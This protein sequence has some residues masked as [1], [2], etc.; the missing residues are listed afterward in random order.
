MRLFVCLFIC[1]CLS[2]YVCRFL[3]LSLFA[4]LPL[5]CLFVSLS[6]YFIISQFTPLSM[7]FCCLSI[8]LTICVCLCVFLSVSSP[9]SLSVYRSV[10]LLAHVSF[11]L[12]VFRPP[13]RVSQAG[14]GPRCGTLINPHLSTA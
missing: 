3:C 12:S 5:A 2:C 10:C 1:L 8:H 6:V 11:R 7:L 9:V 4:C 13:V 14:A